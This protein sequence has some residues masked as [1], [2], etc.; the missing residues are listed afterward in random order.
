MIYCINIE[1]VDLKSKH[2]LDWASKARGKNEPRYWLIN[3]DLMFNNH[4]RDPQA[5]LLLRIL[6]GARNQGYTTIM[7]K[8]EG[9]DV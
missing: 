1:D 2:L 9:V 3:T 7:I 6:D 4:N 8:K 5:N